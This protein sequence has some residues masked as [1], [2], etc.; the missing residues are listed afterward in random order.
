MPPK[1][2]EVRVHKSPYWAFEQI[3]RANNS[4]L[5]HQRVHEIAITKWNEM[6]P[7]AKQ[8]YKTIMHRIKIGELTEKIQ[9]G[10][11]VEADLR[12]PD[13]KTACDRKAHKAQL[14]NWI[15]TDILKSSKFV[16]CSIKLHLQTDK[17]DTKYFIQDCPLTIPA[18][19]TVT[20]FDMRKIQNVYHA[21]LSIPKS[22][23]PQGYTSTVKEFGDEHKI[24]MSYNKVY[25]SNDYV[26]IWNK[27][28]QIVAANSAETLDY[29]LYVFSE[30]V[31]DIKNAIAFLQTKAESGEGINVQ[32]IDDLLE[33][34]INVI[35]N[36]EVS[37]E[38]IA[39]TL[40]DTFYD[41]KICSCK[42]HEDEF[43]MKI[44]SMKINL[45]VVYLFYRAVNGLIGQ[46]LEEA[47]M[48]Q[49]LEQLNVSTL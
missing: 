27:I 16:T 2:Y 22:E 13:E 43:D 3:M 10:K 42:F 40:K 14:E 18:E 24:P 7:E 12:K 37:M 36:S 32:V 1:L 44:C 26:K 30:Q 23:I 20:V 19:I 6:T 21:I 39:Q 9:N 49:E 34:C 28:K 15:S 17:H 29:P 33:V 5:T 38:Q 4:H 41:F 45:K 31:H 35:Q 47:H 48:P 8:K 46:P 11:F 25:S